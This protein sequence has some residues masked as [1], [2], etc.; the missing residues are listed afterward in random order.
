MVL[1]FLTYNRVLLHGSFRFR[2]PGYRI[3]ATLQLVE[4][5]GHADLWMQHT[6][7]EDIARYLTQMIKI[8][9]PAWRGERHTFSQRLPS[10][11][12]P[13]LPVWYDP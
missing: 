12:L 8:G 7:E 10:E 1:I 2:R 11:F 6:Y 13:P 3:S 4:G 5:R 9:L